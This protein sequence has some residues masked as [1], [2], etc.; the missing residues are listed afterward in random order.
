MF[1]DY[2]TRKN[3]NEDENKNEEMTLDEVKTQID[4]D[5]GRRKT[6]NLEE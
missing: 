6:V 2:F 5:Y 1:Y 4:N 3:E